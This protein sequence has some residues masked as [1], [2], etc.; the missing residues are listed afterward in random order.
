MLEA[1]I[2]QRHPWNL[3]NKLVVHLFAD[4]ASAPAHIAAVLW[5]D[6]AV[7]STHCPPPEAIRETLLA[8]DD[9]QIMALELLSIA[10]GLS[11]FVKECSGRQIVIHSDNAGAACAVFWCV[12]CVSCIVI[13][14]S[15]RSNG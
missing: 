5:V 1:G 11:T 10:L 4:A 3:P 13:H 2:V 6:G 15:R 12:G 8:R 7:L 14:R 9:Q